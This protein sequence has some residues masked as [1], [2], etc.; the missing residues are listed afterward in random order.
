MTTGRSLRLGE[1]VLAGGVLALGLFIAVETA[2]L[3][4][5][6]SQAAVGPRLFPSLVA[7]GL[8]LVGAAL[9][10]EAFFGHIAHEGGFELDWPAVGLVS[11]GLVLQM[12]ILE[13]V[14][15]IVA[16]VLLFTLTARAFGS[17]RLLLDL[18]IGL[19]L[20][21]LTFAVFSYG[22]DLSLPAGELAERLL[23]PAEEGESP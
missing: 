10:R 14:G 23:L 12:L 18:A 8:L 17:R 5:A 22:L 19:G 7:A 20:G 11:A 4:V 3:E 15:W 16:A 21:V 6:P 1:M 13:W 2:M 9:L